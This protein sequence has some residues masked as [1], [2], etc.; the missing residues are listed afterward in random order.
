MLTEQ[1]H[2]AILEELHSTGRVLARELAERLQVSEDTI[3]RDLRELSTRGALQRVH[4]GALPVSPA[5]ANLARRSAI[6]VDEKQA[7]GR[8]AASL[9]ADGQLVFVDGGTSTLAMVQQLPA[10]LR[11]TVATHSPVIA[12]ALIEHPTVEVLMLGG[13]LFKHSGVAVGAGVAQAIQALRADCYFL[14]VTGV[15]AGF[16]LSTGD[17]EEAQVKALLMASAAETVLMASSDKLGKVSP[18]RVAP[19][20]ALSTLIVTPQAGP[21]A[22]QALRLPGLEILV[23]G[24]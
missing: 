23:S 2:L 14:G 7:L 16:G 19:L 20:S 13:R 1:R 15:E 6:A 10:T 3:R 12:A 24:G 11:A 9:I 21:A 18:Y 17:A 5:L 4:G 8:H 22:L